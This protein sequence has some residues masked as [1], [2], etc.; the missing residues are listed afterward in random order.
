MT[1]DVPAGALVGEQDVATVTVA[2][3]GDPTVFADVMLTTTVVSRGVF[4]PLVMNG[5][6][7]P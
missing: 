4:L 6:I 5:F 2:S 7:V 3:Q 1:V